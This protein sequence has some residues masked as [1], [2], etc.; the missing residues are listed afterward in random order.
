MALVALLFGS[1]VADN[2]WN[3]NAYNSLPAVLSR[4]RESWKGV[5][6]HFRNI[7]PT[8]SSRSS[9][10]GSSSSAADI[11][12]DLEREKAMALFRSEALMLETL[13]EFF[14]QAEAKLKLLLLAVK[15][16]DAAEIRETVHW[17]R[18][19]A[20]F[21]FSPIVLAACIELTQVS[22]AKPMPDL[23]EATDALG[24]ALTKLQKHIPKA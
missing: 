11:S 14:I 3:G 16:N 17:F 22:L 7:A 9:S 24:I 6:Q 12:P 18:G 8:R 5:E 13:E 20:S 15:S 19:G 23:I 2:S 21:L 1:S 10:W 4:Q